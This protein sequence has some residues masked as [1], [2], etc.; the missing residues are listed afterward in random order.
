MLRCGFSL[1]DNQGFCVFRDAE[2]PSFSILP[3]SSVAKSLSLQSLHSSNG[4]VN[5]RHE[6]VVKIFAE[7]LRQSSS[8]FGICFGN[9]EMTIQ[10]KDKISEDGNYYSLVPRAS[11]AQPMAKI[12]KS[13]QPMSASNPRE[14]K[15]VGP[16]MDMQASACS[17]V[18]SKNVPAVKN[19]NES[20]V[21]SSIAHAPPSSGM[22]HN[23][24]TKN[25]EAIN[26]TSSTAVRP[27]PAS[28]SN[29]VKNPKPVV[30]NQSSHEADM[31]TQE[32]EAE[33]PVGN[34][35]AMAQHTADPW[36]ESSQTHSTSKESTKKRKDPPP[37]EDLSPAFWETLIRDG[38]ILKTTVPSM[39][40]FLASVKLPVSGKKEVLIDRI[41]KHFNMG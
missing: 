13:K 12:A 19:S 6:S 14:P 3:I 26:Q 38:G 36:P 5:Y 24:S 21:V 39:K 16:G 31:P 8:F 28:A 22:K 25:N 29:L 10:L 41:R 23:E 20:A 15:R 4:S 40:Q 18:A 2:W 30:S 33:Q 7:D 34:G 27:V 1:P 11:I 35:K 9:S 37:A 17:T 32:T